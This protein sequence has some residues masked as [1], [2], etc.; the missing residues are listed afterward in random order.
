MINSCDQ[1]D[2]VRE[3]RNYGILELGWPPCKIAEPQD[4]KARQITLDRGGAAKSKH[5]CCHCCLKRSV[6]IDEENICPCN[7]CL[8]KEGQCLHSRCIDDDYYM[9]CQFE[10]RSIIDRCPTLMRILEAEL[11]D[12]SKDF[13]FLA[14]DIDGRYVGR[15]VKHQRWIAITPIR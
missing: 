5:E 15:Y 4:T 7:L 1:L 11:P 6:E 3:V 14:I 12:V 13:R 8:K 9:A 2:F 10:K